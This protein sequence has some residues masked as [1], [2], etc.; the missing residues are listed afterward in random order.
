MI[1]TTNL[2]LP[3]GCSHNSFHC[4][5]TFKD[6]SSSYL[7]LVDHLSC[8]TG[9]D[10]N[11]EDMENSRAPGRLGLKN[12]DIPGPIKEAIQENQSEAPNEQPQSNVYHISSF[13]LLNNLDLPR[14]KRYNDDQEYLQIP[15]A[16]A[17]NP[18]VAAS[19][20]PTTAGRTLQRITLN[21]PRKL[22]QRFLPSDEGY[23]TRTHS[24]VSKLSQRDDSSI[25]TYRSNSP[26]ISMLRSQEFPRAIHARVKKTCC[27]QKMI[28]TG[29]ERRLPI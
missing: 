28:V 11:A 19:Q 20:S 8:F 10:L 3:P 15:T 7:N 29:Q 17:W 25:S 18:A 14:A 22:D 26:R 24:E 2:D 13:E 16:P 4:F 5:C 9:L 6:W 27:V 21:L 1:F 12:L 23:Y